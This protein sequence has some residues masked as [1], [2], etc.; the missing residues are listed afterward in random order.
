MKL[1]ALVLIGGVL[2]TLSTQAKARITEVAWVATST[3]VLGTHRARFEASEQW[4]RVVLTGEIEDFAF[5]DSVSGNTDIPGF[6]VIKVSSIPK[7]P[8]GC[9]GGQALTD[10]IFFEG[11]QTDIDNAW[12]GFFIF[13]Q[14]CP[15]I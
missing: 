5:G 11:T 8:A 7:N 2:A 14:Q 9:Y 4:N 6:T 15:C 1:F 13:T 12:I 3:E 10:N